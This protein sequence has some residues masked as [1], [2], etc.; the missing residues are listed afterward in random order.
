[1]EVDRYILGTTPDPL[2]DFGGQRLIQASCQLRQ[3]FCAQLLV[4]VSS[5]RLRIGCAHQIG[6]DR[7]DGPS[8]GRDTHQHIQQVVRCACEAFALHWQVFSKA[9]ASMLQY[10]LIGQFK[11]IICQGLVLPGSFGITYNPR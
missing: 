11:R 5:N 1:M 10:F 7:L 9:F 3:V 6:T 4:E 8:V 2:W